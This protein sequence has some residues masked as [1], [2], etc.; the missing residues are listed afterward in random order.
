MFALK[1]ELLRILIFDTGLSFLLLGE[2]A[3]SQNMASFL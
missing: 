1:N 3:E 2:E